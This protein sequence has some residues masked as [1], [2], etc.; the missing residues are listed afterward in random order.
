MIRPEHG[1]EILQSKVSFFKIPS[2]QLMSILVLQTRSYDTGAKQLGPGITLPDPS[3]QLL[4]VNIHM[5]SLFFQKI[6]FGSSH[7]HLQLSI[8]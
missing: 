3:M 2:V 1:L 5:F 8:L 4:V 7:S 6:L